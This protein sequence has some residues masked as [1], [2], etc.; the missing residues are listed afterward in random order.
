MEIPGNIHGILKSSE[1]TAIVM[2]CAVQYLSAK[3]RKALWFSDTTQTSIKNQISG[4]FHRDLR[5]RFGVP[6]E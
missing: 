6:E 5:G 1:M 2:F 4:P 3:F